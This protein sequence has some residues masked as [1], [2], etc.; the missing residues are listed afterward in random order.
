M[1]APVA[2]RRRSLAVAGLLGLGGCSLF[3]TART[4]PD[5]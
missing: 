2:G 1:V 3:G 4:P 5:P